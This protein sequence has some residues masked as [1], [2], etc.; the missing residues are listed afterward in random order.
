[1]IIFFWD[2]LI[3]KK[4]KKKKKDF[5]SEEVVGYLKASLLYV[6]GE[7][8]VWVKLIVRIVWVPL[9]LNLLVN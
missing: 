9:A 6:T 8:P 4:K 3:I 1:M 7:S 5:A 2:H